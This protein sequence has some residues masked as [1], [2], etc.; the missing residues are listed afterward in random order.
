[1]VDVAQLDSC[2]ALTEYAVVNYTVGGQIQKPLGNDHN[3]CRPYGMFKSKDGY[4]FFGG[5]TDRFWKTTCEFFGEPELLNDPEIDTMPKRFDLDTYNRK[6][7]PKINEWFS[8]YTS[9]ELQDALAEK[10]PL[11]AIHSIDEVMED[12]QLNYRNMFIEGRYGD[13]SA[14]VFGT[15]IKLSGTPLEPSATAPDIGQHNTEVFAEFFGYDEAK[16]A[17]LK[18]KGVI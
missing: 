3:L 13:A 15:P 7:L 12:P 4:V 8:R 9:Q 11:T 5:Y 17:E 16:L 14:K 18:E 2:V 10:V 1:M 6:V